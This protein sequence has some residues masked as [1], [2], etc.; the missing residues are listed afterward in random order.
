MFF[1]RFVFF[2]RKLRSDASAIVQYRTIQVLSNLH[3]YVLGKPVMSWMLYG[4]MGAQVTT[5]YMVLTSLKLI[6][7]G[8]GLLF[9]VVAIDTF[10][11]I[12]V[13]FKILSVPYLS[14]VEFVTIAKTL[15]NKRRDAKWANRFLKSCAPLKIAMGDGNFFDRLSPFV[16]Y[17]VCVDQVIA[18]LLF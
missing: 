5:L 17:K 9:I 18:L 8:A 1:K 12:Q 15:A 11:I 16:I 7:I 4:V 14:S 2:F 6:P 10:I 13:V 3:G